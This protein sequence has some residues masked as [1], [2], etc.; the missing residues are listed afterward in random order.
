MSLQ[1]A[2]KKKKPA[3][4]MPLQSDQE[5]K[6]TAEKKEHG[7]GSEPRCGTLS[8]RFDFYK[9]SAFTSYLD[10]L[11]QWPPR[12]IPPL[13]GLHP[14]PHIAS[15]GQPGPRKRALFSGVRTSTTILRNSTSAFIG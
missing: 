6:G 7:L 1:S 10:E 15:Q 4:C 5:P 11:Q 14:G 8:T 12:S 9:P 3:L 13:A 2:C